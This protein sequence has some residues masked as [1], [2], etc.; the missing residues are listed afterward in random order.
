MGVNLSYLNNKQ[1]VLFSCY[2]VSTG[3]ELKDA[4]KRLGKKEFLENLKYAFIDES[5]VTSL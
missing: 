5:A 1:G 4:L 3:E 2:G